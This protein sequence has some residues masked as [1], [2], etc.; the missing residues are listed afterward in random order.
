MTH[1]RLVLTRASDTPPMAR[2]ERRPG[3]GPWDIDR[4]T[5]VLRLTLGAYE[6]EVD[7]E[8]CTTS[9]QVLDWICQVARKQ[10]GGDHAAVVSG[11][12]TALDDVLNPQAHLCS[13]GQS[14]RLTR[15]AVRKLV[16]RDGA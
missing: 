9:A 11:L 3:W 2:G 14:K 5:F 12:V 10:W 15:A 8:R 13:S 7:L 1:R 6:Y 16:K 4:E